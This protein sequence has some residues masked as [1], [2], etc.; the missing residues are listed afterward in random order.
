MSAGL[1]IDRCLTMAAYSAFVAL[2]AYVEKNPEID[3]PEA[4]DGICR[5]SA[6]AV[7]LDYGGGIMILEQVTVASGW[8]DDKSGLRTVIYELVKR[9]QPWW[10]RLVPYGRD[11]ARAVLDEDQ[12]QCLREAGLFDAVPAPDIVAWWDDIASFVR[13]TIDTER[14]ARAR[15]A[16]RLSLELERERLRKLGINQQPEW[17]SLE[18]NS[19]GYD[20][21]SYGLEDGRLATRLIEVKS[22]VSDTIFITRNEWENADSAGRQYYFHVWKL[23]EKT[24]KEYPASDIKPH[25]PL[26]QGAGA[27]HDTLVNLQ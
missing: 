9:G 11:K 4:I 18:D 8:R 16:E 17:V 2:R 24:I 6:D 22:T 26:D 23:P 7:G 20:I 3:M 1:D 27:W 12:Q 5:T 15:E 14:M 21:R 19:L 10:L 13:G 25:I